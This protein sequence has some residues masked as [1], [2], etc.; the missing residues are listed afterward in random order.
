MTA[1]L[2]LGCALAV[3]VPA[4]LLHYTADDARL[5]AGLSASP[6]GWPRVL[7]AHFVTVVPLGLLLAGRLRTDIGHP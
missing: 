7:V 3:A 5:A 1:R 6:F 2:L 4:A